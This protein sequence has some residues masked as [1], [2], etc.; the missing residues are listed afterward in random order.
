MPLVEKLDAAVEQVRRMV[1]GTP[2]IGVVLGSGLGDFVRD[3]PVDSRIPFQDI[4]GFPPVSVKGHAGCL[5]SG[6]LQDRHIVILQGR[7]HFYEGHSMMDVVF[8]VRTLCRM[9]IETLVLTNAAGGIGPGL[10]PGDLMV[11]RDHINLMGDNPLRGSNSSELGPRFPDL[12]AVY[13]PDLR[14]LARRVLKDTGGPM[15]EGI[16][17]AMAGP[18]YETP[19]EVRMLAAL[20]ANAVGMS[21]VP[22]AV[23]AR[24]MGARV[25][26]ISCITNLAAGISRQ[27]LSHTEVTETASRTA[28]R[29]QS[30]LTAL[31]E[32][33]PLAAT[34]RI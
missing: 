21:T 27:P 1:D 13:D 34:V 2:G 16:Y 3:F 22:E 9:G 26:A 23:A 31:L 11:I 33:I 28:A 7:A 18:A 15:R 32:R 17:A 19:A 24:H 10:R 8:P 6:R 20:G 14:A 5:I 12:S 29:F 25:V 4:P 30:V